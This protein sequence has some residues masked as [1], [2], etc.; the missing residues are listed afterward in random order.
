MPKIM[1]LCYLLVTLL[2]IHAASADT[3]IK[4]T[5]N[6]ADK[7]VVVLNENRTAHKVSTLSDNPGL[8]CLALQY[9]KA[10]QG[11]CGAV[12]GSD[13]KKPPESQ[14]AEVFAPNCGVKASTLAPITGRFLGC[15]T[16]YVH[17]PEAFSDILIRNQKSLD[18]LY[19]K[20]HTQVGAAVTG[21]D[22]GSP[23]FW[24]VLFSSGKPNSTF[25]FEG[26]V[27]KITKPGCFSGA[28]DVCSGASHWSPLTGICLF[29]TSVIFALGFG[30]LL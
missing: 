22:G 14:F 2:F 8:A 12:G 1:T 21:T 6:P 20:N 3:Q 24:C 4:V 5:D 26:G 27:A 23:Y 13:A 29:A 7:L 30:F 11:D 10:Y 28:N 25:A 16:K 9:I 15:Q 18:I 17:A 19:S